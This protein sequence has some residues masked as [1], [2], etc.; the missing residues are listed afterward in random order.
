MAS[1]SPVSAPRH[2]FPVPAFELIDSSEMIEEETLPTYCAGKYYPAHIGEVLDNRYQIAAKLGYG[3]TSTVWLCRDIIQSKYVA[4]KIYVHGVDNSPEIPVYN[5][6]NS[7]ET[8]HLG[9]NFIRKLFNHLYIDG[10]NG[11]DETKAFSTVEKAEIETPS[12]SKVIDQNR[13]IYTSQILL[14]G[15]GFP[16]FSDFG[17]ARF[18]NESHD[19]DIMPNMYR[20]PEVVLKMNWDCKVDIWNIAMVAWDTV[21]RKTLFD[22]RN[23]GNIFDDRVHVAEMVAFLG[24]PPAEFIK[25]SRVFSAFWDDNGVWKNLVPIPYITLGSLASDIE[26]EDKED[27][28]LFLRRAL[29]WLPEERPTA[30]ELLSDKWLMKGLEIPKRV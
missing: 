25:R 1:Y 24:P 13:T 16:L 28:L 15:N 27:F 5:R 30:R 23:S 7:E 12:P 4:L 17:E 8:D 29:K 6:I 2:P 18:G 22:G 20:P 14:P 10:P 21:C 19:E 26:G 9:K 3:V 11:L